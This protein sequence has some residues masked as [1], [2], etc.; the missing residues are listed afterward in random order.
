MKIK[1]ILVLVIVVGCF[2]LQTFFQVWADQNNDVSQ[3]SEELIQKIQERLPDDWILDV[4]PGYL[5][6]QTKQKINAVVYKRNQPAIMRP[7][8]H[9]YA[10]TLRLMEYVPRDTFDRIQRKNQRLEEEALKVYFRG[11]MKN[12]PVFKGRTPDWEHEYFPRTADEKQAVERYKEC[13][14]QLIPLPD[15]YYQRQSFVLDERQLVFEDKNKEQECQSVLRHV[16]RL[17]EEY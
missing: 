11:N 3:I 15:V 7:E 16:M 14:A 6:V 8:R 13:Y 4:Q 2:C 17:F 1:N 10:F 9:A 12:I 5:R